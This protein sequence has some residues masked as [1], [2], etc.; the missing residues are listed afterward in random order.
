MAR[1]SNTATFGLAFFALAACGAPPPPVPPPTSQ[2]LAPREQL[3]R[4]VEHYWEEHLPV[5]NS[6][7]PQFLAD[8][9][10]VER[11]YLNELAA[12]SRDGLDVQSKLT[13][14]IFKRQRE[15]LVEGF[16]YPAELIPLS[17]LGRVLEQIEIFAADTDQHPWASAADYENWLQRIEDYVNWTRQAVGNMREGLRRG[18]TSPRAVIERAIRMLTPLSVDSAANRLFEPLRSMPN[19]IRDPDRS[20][21]TALL[22]SAMNDKLLPANRA[23]HDFLLREYLPRGRAGIALSDL[24]LGAKWYAY[25]I[26]RATDSALSADEIHSLGLAEVER[27]RARMP[28]HEAPPAAAPAAALELQNAYQDM[29]AQVS[30][31]LPA[32]F[33]ETPEAGLELRT[34]EWL[35]DSETPLYYEA[36]A[37]GAKSHAI[38]YIS[39]KPAG[40]AAASLA[41]FLQQGVPGRHLQMALQQHRRDLPRFRQWNREPAFEQG[42]GLYAATLGEQMGLV[43]DDAA[44]LDALAVQ[45]RCAVA[46]VADTGLQVKNWTLAQALDYLHEQLSVDA[47]TAQALVDEYALNPGDALACKMGELKFAGL[48]AKAQQALGSR[49]E[50]HGFHSEIL[51][52]GAM[53]LDILDAKMKLWMDASR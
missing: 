2:Q 38:L 29:S 26:R 30:V 24:P 6:I 46:L 21:L 5:G 39:T 23:L 9:L 1:F 7:S 10:N 36:A 52:D 11:R 3:S 42:W 41:G 48:R 37:S 20:R 35:Q 32:L 12:I 50:I 8:S 4:L 15:V 16:T 25:R 31:A 22:S 14:D 44:K 53:P 27:L 19:A 33:S 49:F 45:L 18:Y 13:Y 43:S 34:T 51:K 17:C 28:P 47:P 40:R